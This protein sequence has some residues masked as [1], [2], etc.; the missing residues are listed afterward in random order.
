MR[1]IIATRC[2]SVVISRGYAPRTALLC[3]IGGHSQ[4]K[5]TFFSAF[6]T[7]FVFPAFTLIKI[8]AFVGM[9]SSLLFAVCKREWCTVSGAGAGHLATPR[10]I[11]GVQIMSLVGKMP[12]GRHK[13]MREK[14]EILLSNV[15]RSK[16]H[17]NIG[18]LPALMIGD[19]IDQCF[20]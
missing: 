3:A 12:P 5:A 6:T 14:S 2:F 13:C 7:S 11:D 10:G 1:S 15:V 8:Y 9:R 20:Q 17:T 18:L 16:S 4:T 19:E